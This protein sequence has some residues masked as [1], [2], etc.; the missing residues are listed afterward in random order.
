MYL[1]TYKEVERF[2]ETISFT[3]LRKNL[4]EVLDRAE[5]D[6]VPVVVTRTK[7][8]SSV[9]LSLEDYR[10]LEE[11]AYLLRSPKNAEWLLES[12]KEADGGK[13]KRRRLIEED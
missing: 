12:L 2:M 8:R 10:S 3:D 7:R 9:I 11:T 5:S 4:T 13:V 6:H 1:N